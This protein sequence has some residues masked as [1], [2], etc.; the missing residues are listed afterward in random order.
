MFFWKSLVI[1][2]IQRML[3]IWSLVPLPFINPAWTSGSSSLENL[4]PSFL[5]PE[6]YF[7]SMQYEC[8]CVV[9]W[10]FLILPFF[11]TGKKILL[12]SCDHHW[13]FQISWHI[14]YQQSPLFIFFLKYPP[15]FSCCDSNTFSTIAS[16]F[17]W[18]NSLMAQI[19]DN[20]PAMWETWVWSLS[21][22]NRL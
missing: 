4:K 15:P 9:V 2:M 19:S 20:L 22:E 10:M 18:D 11:R 17:R 12:Q 14:E 13:V 1:C 16:N 3:A 21:W 8:I 5:N 7:S 6:H